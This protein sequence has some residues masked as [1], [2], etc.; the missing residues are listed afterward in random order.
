MYRRDSRFPRQLDYKRPKLDPKFSSFLSFH[1]SFQKT[2]PLSF[3][4]LKNFFFLFKNFRKI[5]DKGSWVT[6]WRAARNRQKSTAPLR[7]VNEKYPFETIFCLIAIARGYLV[8]FSEILP[9]KINLLAVG[10]DSWVSFSL[11]N[12]L[13]DIYSDQVKTCNQYQIQA[14]NFNFWFLIWS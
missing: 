11:R 9:W 7:H 8:L 12:F 13:E 5:F 6:H 14:F 3:V 2:D 4:Y 10:W 1:I